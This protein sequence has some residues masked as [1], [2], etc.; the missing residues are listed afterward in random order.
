MSKEEKEEKINNAQNEEELEKVVE[1]IKAEEKAEE[2][3]IKEITPEEERA[4]IKDE[5][6]IEERSAKEFSVI[7]R[8]GEDKMD[9][10][11]FRNSKEYVDAY[12]EYVKTG[13]DKELRA[14]IT[15][16]GYSTGNSATVEVPDLVYDIVKTAW[17]R[18]ELMGLVRTIPVKGDLQVQFEVSADGATVHTEG[19][20]TVSEENLTLRNRVNICQ[21]NQEMDLNFR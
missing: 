19:Y 18:E 13:E 9:L 17:E 4:L 5:E 2:E 1:E 11:E 20:G 3:E 21:V 10:K 14:L 15:T 16:G 6:K 8:K 12:A 7:E